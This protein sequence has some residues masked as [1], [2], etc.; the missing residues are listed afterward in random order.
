MQVFAFT[1]NVFLSKR[2]LVY[3]IYKRCL[4][5]VLMYFWWIAYE[6]ILLSMYVQLLSILVTV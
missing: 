2:L 3:K 4:L 6:L 1:Y 5:Y